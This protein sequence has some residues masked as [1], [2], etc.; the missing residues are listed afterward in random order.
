MPRNAGVTSWKPLNSEDYTTDWGKEIFSDV[1]A[2]WAV[3]S[4]TQ[5]AILQKDDSVMLADATANP[6]TIQLPD[7]ER[8]AGKKY[9]VKKID[10]SAN[11]VTIQPLRSTQTIDGAASKTLTVQYQTRSFVAGNGQ[12]W[13]L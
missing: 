5:G 6:I 13:E 12:W 9:W 11:V 7:A 4:A 8:L 1:Y 10:A 3:N 2:L